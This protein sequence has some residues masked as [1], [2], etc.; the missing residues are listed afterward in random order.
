MLY[1]GGE[2]ITLSGLV[3]RD[4]S[5]PES[6]RSKIDDDLYPE[7]GELGIEERADPA[8]GSED[9]AW[10]NALATDDAELVGLCNACDTGIAREGFS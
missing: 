4:D 9:E 1:R 5:K 7:S 8:P 2:N 6:W 10:E 3:G